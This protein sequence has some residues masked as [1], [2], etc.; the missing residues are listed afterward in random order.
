MHLEKYNLN[1][2]AYSDHLR[3]MLHEIMKLNDLTDVTFL[4]VSKNL[5]IKDI[6]KYVEGNEE[7]IADIE[8]VSDHENDTELASEHNYVELTNNRLS[9]SDSNNSE[10]QQNTGGLFNC[11]KCES[12][13][14]TRRGL[15]YHKQSKHEG[16]KYACKLCDYK[17]TTQ[18][19]VNYHVQSKH[20]GVRY[21]CKTCD[22]QA[23]HISSLKLHIKSIHE[24]MKYACNQC[25][26]QAT[27]QGNLKA[28]VE[29]K[30]E[31]SKYA[32]DQCNYQLTSKASLYK[33][34]KLEH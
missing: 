25:E 5:E 29:A 14:T 13:F 26:F 4:N 11:G 18:P 16:I 6:S 15:I 32:C 2:H 24:G 33:H 22:Y 20:K 34:K 23:T 17:A 19:G 8:E 10:L 1:W 30:H 9:K 31:G 28:H 3:E 12:Q 21:P 27:Q 7:N